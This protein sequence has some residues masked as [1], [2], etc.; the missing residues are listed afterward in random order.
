[1]GRGDNMNCD[2]SE[3][4]RKNGFDIT[5]DERMYIPGLHCLCYNYRGNAPANQAEP[6]S[7]KAVQTRTL[8]IERMK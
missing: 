1:M 4:I 8:L 5:R 2:S 7:A 3:L 6:G